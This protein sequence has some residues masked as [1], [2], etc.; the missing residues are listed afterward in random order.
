MELKGRHQQG[1]TPT[2]TSTIGANPLH[3]V[4]S[5]DLVTGAG[6]LDSI[7]LNPLHGVERITVQLSEFIVRRESM[8]P[9]HG[10]ESIRPV[11]VDA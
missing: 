3:G 2:R 11:E 5:L 10:V 8:N 1:G 6:W 7:R 9:L 4:E